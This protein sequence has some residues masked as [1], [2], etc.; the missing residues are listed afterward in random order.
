MPSS[1]VLH[2]VYMRANHVPISAVLLLANGHGYCACGFAGRAAAAVIAGVT[3]G[4]A[5]AVVALTSAA[6]ARAAAALRRKRTQSGKRTHWP[7]ACCREGRQCGGCSCCSLFAIQEGVVLKNSVKGCIM[8]HTWALGDHH[9]V[10][11]AEVVDAGAAPVQHVGTHRICRLNTPWHSA[12]LC[13]MS[14]GRRGA[15]RLQQQLLL[16]LP[17]QAQPTPRWVAWIQQQPPS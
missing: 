15:R 14:T 8:Q 9:S 12:Y 2:P 1:R 5:A 11:N 3:A 6:L 4:A 7:I 16:R 13:L 17:C 10:S